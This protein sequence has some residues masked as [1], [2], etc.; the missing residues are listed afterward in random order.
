VHR[1]RRGPAV[2][3][4]GVT[5]CLIALCAGL[6]AAGRSP[7]ALGTQAHGSVS[8]PA[9][10]PAAATTAPATGPSSQPL[11]TAHTSFV[12]VRLVIEKLRVSAPIEVR[13]TDTNNVMEAPDRPADVAWYRFTA[14]PGSGS[15]AVFAGHRDFAKVGPAVFWN[16]GDLRSGDS[17]DVVSPQQ[18]EI[19]YRVGQVWSYPVDAMPMSKVLAVDVGDEVTLITC[20][21]RYSRS[22]GYD[23]RL[24]VR[25]QRVL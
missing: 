19:R 2:A 22:T 12:P 25:A 21:G 15:N 23:H 7:A 9:G 10:L 24:V 13:S 4:V 14:R 8:S 6:W 5:A 20:A 1:L 11:P 18:T 16:L 17:I 3:I